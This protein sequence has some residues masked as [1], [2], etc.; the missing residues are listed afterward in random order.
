MIFTRSAAI[1]IFLRISG[2]FVALAWT[3]CFQEN[4]WDKKRIAEKRLCMLGA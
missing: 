1:P 3:G 4:L 2:V